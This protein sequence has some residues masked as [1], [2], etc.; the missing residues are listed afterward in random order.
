MTP[1]RLAAALGIGLVALWLVLAGG[2]LASGGLPAAASG[3]MIAVFPPSTS[4]DQTLLSI[5]AADARIVR[6]SW[7][8]FAVV[9]HDD[10]PGLAGRLRAAGAVIVAREMVAA[11]LL[12]GGCV[13]GHTILP[14]PRFGSGM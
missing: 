4:A 9:V 12:A 13:G 7:F 1:A 11:F 8:A 2:L 3:R 10:A 14:L 6:G 5:A